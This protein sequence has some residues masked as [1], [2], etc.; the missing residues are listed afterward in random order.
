MS[1]RRTSQLCYLDIVWSLFLQVVPEA[2]VH[3][4]AQ[5][6]QRRLRAEQVEGRHVE[7]VQKAEQLLPTSWHQGP[8]GSPFQAALHNRLNVVGGSLKDDET[9]MKT[10]L[11]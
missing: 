2:V 10:V 3:P 9:G 6:L 11:D 5:K 4:Q 1:S 7:V 8:F